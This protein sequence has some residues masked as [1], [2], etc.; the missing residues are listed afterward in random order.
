MDIQQIKRLVAQEEARK[1]ACSPPPAQPGEV[2]P[3]PRE[4]CRTGAR[5][6]ERLK[7]GHAKRRGALVR[8]AEASCPARLGHRLPWCDGRGVQCDGRGVQDPGTYSSC[9]VLSANWSRHMPAN[10]HATLSTPPEPLISW[11][12]G[13]PRPTPI[14][15]GEQIG[16]RTTTP[17]PQTPA[18][19][20]RHHASPLT[21]GATSA[22]T[23]QT[24]NQCSLFVCLLDTAMTVRS[25]H[26][27]A[28]FRSKRQPASGC[29]AEALPPSPADTSGRIPLQQCQIGAPRGA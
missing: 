18:P 20:A 26:A 9:P 15:L 4:R 21:R 17:E 5:P 11:Q 12:S 10:R 19:A 27:T 29:P 8:Y 23:G 14:A 7:R 16:T 6:R 25:R 28:W 2:T 1:R 24:P 13:T 3:G 22:R